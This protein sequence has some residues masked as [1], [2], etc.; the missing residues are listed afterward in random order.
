MSQNQ[1]VGRDSVTSCKRAC[2]K[3]LTADDP[4][5]TMTADGFEGAALER[6]LRGKNW[7]LALSTYTNLDRWRG[8][9]DSSMLSNS[10][11]VERFSMTPKPAPPDDPDLTSALTSASASGSASSDGFGPYRFLQRLGEGG[12]GEVWLAEQLARSAVRSRSR[13]SRPGMDT[14]PGR[15]ALRGGASGAGA[16]GPPR[17]REGLRRRD[18]RRKAGRTS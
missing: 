2:G 3:T 13:S 14:R 7:Q 1:F 4:P 10:C 17:H 6:V 12:M 11:F 15:R 9:H 16:D 18:A 5:R 8:P